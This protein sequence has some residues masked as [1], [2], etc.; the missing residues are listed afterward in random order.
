MKI[1]PASFRSREII[2]HAPGR[3]ALKMD[4]TVTMLNEEADIPTLQVENR[5]KTTPFL[6]QQELM[7]VDPPPP[8]G[9]PS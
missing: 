1:G 5:V 6:G 3:R 7:G 9:R 4:A 8:P 2:D